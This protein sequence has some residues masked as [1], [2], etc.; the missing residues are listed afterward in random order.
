MLGK[1]LSIA[2]SYRIPVMITNQ[3]QGNVTGYGPAFNPAGGH[4][5]AHACTHRVMYKK[6][7]RNSRIV[8][9]LDSPNISDEESVRIAI[10][11][12]GITDEGALN[13]S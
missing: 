11:R 1:L 5:M 8:N 13:E 10:T 2:S 7:T 9:V 6:A 12:A 4:V 3:V